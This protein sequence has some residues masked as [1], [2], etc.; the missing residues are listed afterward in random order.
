MSFENYW[1]FFL[2]VIKKKSITTQSGKITQP[3]CSRNRASCVQH[4]ILSCCWP[5]CSLTRDWLHPPYQFMDFID[6]GLLRNSWSHSSAVEPT[7]MWAPS[8]G[9][10]VEA[11]VSPRAALPAA[12]TGASIFHCFFMRKSLFIFTPQLSSELSLLMSSSTAE[13]FWGGLS[14]GEGCQLYLTRAAAF[15]LRGFVALLQLLSFLC[16]VTPAA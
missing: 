5:I 1:F 3:G 8:D 2:S 9:C 13:E 16:S 15:H 4:L 11:A 12:S 7:S 14:P 10:E 6:V